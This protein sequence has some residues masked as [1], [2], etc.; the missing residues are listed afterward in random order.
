MDVTTSEVSR[1]FESRRDFYAFLS[2]AF[3]EEPDDAFFDKLSRAPLPIRLAN[4]DFACGCRY[5]VRA[6]RQRTVYSRGLIAADYAGLLIGVE[7]SQGPEPYESLHR[8]RASLIMQ[9]PRDQVVRAYRREGFAV[10]PDYHMPEDHIH[11]ELGFLGVLAGRAHEAL[12]AGDATEA[13]RLARALQNFLHDHV[14]AWVPAFLD[15]VQKWAK[16]D[17]YRGIAL[18]AKGFL[19]DEWDLYPFVVEQLGEAAAA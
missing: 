17:Y 14:L 15:D 7:T 9:E 5:L 12:D 19:A 8:G 6:M 10:S 18:L 3:K 1:F 4:E 13:L 2:A 11:L 16:T